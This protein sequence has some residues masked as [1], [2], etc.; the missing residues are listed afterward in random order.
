MGPADAVLRRRGAHRREPRHPVGRCGMVAIDAEFADHHGAAVSPA[1]G[2][3]RPH[4]ALD[5]GD[6]EGAAR[7][8]RQIVGDPLRTGGAER[9]EQSGEPRIARPDREGH[10]VQPT[11][12]IGPD[13]VRPLMGED[14]RVVVV[15]GVDGVEIG[16]RCRGGQVPDALRP[17]GGDDEGRRRHLAPHRR[18]DRRLHR[19]PRRVVE[20]R[21]VEHFR[22]HLARHP[23]FDQRPEH[24]PRLDHRLACRLRV[25]SEE[26]AE[27]ITAV[28]VDDDGESR[29]RQRIEP[30]ADRAAPRR[31]L[32]PRREA[33]HDALRRHRQAHVGEA[34]PRQGAQT[35]EIRRPRHRFVEP[36]G[37]REAA[38]QFGMDRRAGRRRCRLLGRGRRRGEGHRGEDRSGEEG[39]SLHRQ[40]VSV[41]RRRIA[42]KLVSR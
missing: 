1:P 29:R 2:A 40:S 37:E 10:V 16:D 5:A 13:P 25:A 17:A 30:G 39:A 3:E 41:R 27:A 34:A 12:R 9:G 21:L 42:A 32:G 20:R 7:K 28:Q 15:D 11:D 18:D 38:R 36:A 19:T 26:V 8:A 35:D 6:A 23:R 33:R 4:V 22:R 24:A 31:D 14:H